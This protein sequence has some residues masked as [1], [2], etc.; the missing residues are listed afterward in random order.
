MGAG[1]SVSAG[2]LTTITV[3][4]ADEPTIATKYNE[5]KIQALVTETVVEKLSEDYNMTLSAEITHE[6]DLPIGVGFGA[7]G[8]GA[9]GTA[10]ALSS[11]ISPELDFSSASQYAH[12]AEVVNHAG[13]GD[14]IAQTVG[15]VE[16]RTKAGAPGIGA[17]TKIPYPDDLTVLLAGSTGLHTKDVLTDP[18]RRATI[19]YVGDYLLDE[20]SEKESLEK[21]CKVS[22]E[23][24][25]SIDLE[26]PRIIGALADLHK[27]GLNLSSQV[28]LGDSVFCICNP[29]DTIQARSILAKYWEEQEIMETSIS[30]TGGHVL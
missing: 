25:A 16:I 2:T 9:L 24:A 22:R 28:M 14:V 29:S 23:F 18:E 11:I 6:S 17:V 7:S 27:N 20:L 10:L 1:F 3:F 4:D 8:A 15:G 13:L 30:S 21:I 5:R 26:P 19:N 12:H